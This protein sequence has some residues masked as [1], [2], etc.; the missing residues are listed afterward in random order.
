M[1]KLNGHKHLQK[2]NSSLL[3]QATLFEISVTS[4]ELAD[5][6]L[7]TE[8]CERSKVYSCKVQVANK[9]ILVLCHDSLMIRNERSV[10]I[11]TDRNLLWKVGLT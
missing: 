7:D 4:T 1:S 11:F 10:E 8:T 9:G 6:S 3:L 5:N 2:A